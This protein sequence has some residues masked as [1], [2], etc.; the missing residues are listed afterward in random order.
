VT[1][2]I[3]VERDGCQPSYA[4]REEIAERAAAAHIAV[5]LP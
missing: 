4:T 5:A 3:S 1:A 2:A